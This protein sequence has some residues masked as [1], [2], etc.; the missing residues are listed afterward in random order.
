[1][2]FH[3]HAIAKTTI[4]FKGGLHHILEA[5]AFIKRNRDFHILNRDANVLDFMDKIDFHRFL[6][7]MQNTKF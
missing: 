1:V 7:L 4:K 2:I 3:H 6:V 5:E